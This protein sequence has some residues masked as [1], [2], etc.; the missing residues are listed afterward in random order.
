MAVYSNCENG[1]AIYENALKAMQSPTEIIAVDVALLLPESARERAQ[2]INAILWAQQQDGFQ[3]DATHLPHITLV[4]LFVQRKNLSSLIQSIDS[5]LRHVSPLS[6]RVTKF[7]KTQTTSHL[8]IERTSEL[9]SLHERLTD[10]VAPFEEPPGTTDTFFGAKEPARPSDVEWV[11]H[12]RSQASGN[13]Y[14]PHITLGVGNLQE[15]AE[16]FDF[17]A[18]RV[19]LCH[20]GRSCACR[21]VLHEWNLR[22]NMKSSL[23]AD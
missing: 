5:I 13:N 14:W 4:Q 8:L 7:G 15:P 19:S 6:L 3:F 12:F 1:L 21:A 9:Q 2:A 22:S 23:H 16:P 11:A 18:S 10:G 17:T 20:L